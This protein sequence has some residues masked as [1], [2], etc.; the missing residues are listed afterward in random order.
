MITFFLNINPINK[1]TVPL[2]IVNEFANLNGTAV[3]NSIYG[4]AAKH[5]KFL[6]SFQLI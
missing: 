2:D 4:T 5:S 1:L 6:I 3:K